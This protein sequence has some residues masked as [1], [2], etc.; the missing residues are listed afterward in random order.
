MTQPTLPDKSSSTGKLGRW[1][2]V[3]I[4]IV[5]VAALIQT[6]RKAFEKLREQDRSIE[7]QI[8]DLNGRLNAR[9]PLT[10]EQQAELEQQILR[11][12]QSRLSWQSIR[13]TRVLGA[14]ALYGIGLLGAATYWWRILV[15]FGNPVRPSSAIA[16]HVVGHLGKYVP[17]KAMVVV[18]RAAA[19]KHAQVPFRVA[20]IAAIMETLSY[21]AVGAGIAGVTLLFVEAP[22]WLRWTACGLG[23]ATLVPT[24]PPVFR[25]LV[26]RLFARRT[27]VSQLSASNYSWTLML[28]GWAM[29]TLGWLATGIAFWLILR[30]M[31]G[32]EESSWVWQDLMVAT[33]AISLAVVVGFASLLPGGAG[34]RELVLVTLLAPTY[35]LP[36]ALAAAVVARLAF[37]VAELIAFVIC[38]NWLIDR[39]RL[40]LSGIPCFFIC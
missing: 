5:V 29:L 12:E 10:T 27:G 9:D 2:K 18:M 34:V 24:L 11:L 6:T 17:G 21:M 25:P 7:Q 39:Q 3:I 36:T 28:F 37:L 4:A 32:V 33:A 31:P 35:G 13:W 26:T 40:A 16:G 38:R 8:L 14:V 19:V 30:A 1:L 20:A 15:A 23:L 22:S